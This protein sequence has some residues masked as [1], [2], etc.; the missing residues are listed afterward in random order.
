MRLPVELRLR[1]YRVNALESTS[2]L[3]PIIVT[4]LDPRTDS[5]NW[6]VYTGPT[7]PLGLMRGDPIPIVFTW[8]RYPTKPDH[9]PHDAM[10]PVNMCIC[11]YIYQGTFLLMAS[12]TQHV[13]ERHKNHFSRALRP[14]QTSRALSILASTL[15]DAVLS[16]QSAPFNTRVPSK[17]EATSVLALT[18]LC[19]RSS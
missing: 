5:K 1:C 18:S 6:H 19:T 12:L 17:R 4:A 2:A 3:T 11:I 16:R 14:Q 15:N 9:D 7:V 8:G 13:L 10:C